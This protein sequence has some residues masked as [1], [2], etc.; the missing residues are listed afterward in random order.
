MQQSHFDHSYSGH[1]L[2]PSHIYN[3]PMAG[4]GN[5]YAMDPNQ[6]TTFSGPAQPFFYQ[7]HIP[8]PPP[9][10]V[11]NSAH[12]LRSMYGNGFSLSNGNAYPDKGM[13]PD[14][15]DDSRDPFESCVD[16]R[17]SGRRTPPETNGER[18]INGMQSSEWYAMTD[19]E[20]VAYMKTQRKD[21]AVKT[22]LCSVFEKTNK[23]PYG[24]ICRF[25]HGLNDLRPPP[26]KHPKYKTQLCDTF[27]EKG[28]CPYGSRCQFIHTSEEEE[29]PEVKVP[30]GKSLNENVRRHRPTL[31]YSSS[32]FAKSS[33]EMPSRPFDTSGLGGGGRGS[34]KGLKKAEQSPVV[35]AEIASILSKIDLK[36][37]KHKLTTGEATFLKELSHRHHHENK[38]NM[39]P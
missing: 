19:A 34:K 31:G 12:F 18:Y 8:M 35:D 30:F 32:K 17:K 10:H 26:E 24:I 21:Q 29:L 5:F 14:E 25:A 4:P 27:T 9:Q 2:P 20:R 13:S 39:D 36:K 6:S 15:S 22:S 38:E 37:D 1:G 28:S 33:R 11:V 7:T 16:H 23:C 3:Y